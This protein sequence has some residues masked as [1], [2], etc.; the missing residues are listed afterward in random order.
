MIGELY[1][2]ALA[3]QAD[4]E[5]EYGD[6]CRVP[7][8]ANRWLSLRP[9]DVSILRRCTGATLDVGSGPGRLT[10][11]L[12]RR[13]VPALGIDINPYAVQ[14]T[15]DAGAEALLGDVFD[16]VPGTG[17]WL[18][19]LL[20][21][22]NIGIGGDPGMLLLRVEELLAPGGSA[23]IELEPPGA[24]KRREHVRLRHGEELGAWFPW[25]HVG[26]N[27]IGDLARSAGLDLIELWTEATRWFAALRSAH[28]H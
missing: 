17:Q 18:H 13:G 9:G 7:L 19:V 5:I 15:R 6:G 1:V 28:E 4:P 2:R 21:D 26:V 24:P 23:L 22:G 8:G 11:A 20:A 25:A 10:A 3:G 14:L 27:H 12:A 16:H